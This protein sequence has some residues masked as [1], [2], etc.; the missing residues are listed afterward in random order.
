MSAFDKAWMV[1]KSLVPTSTDD[2]MGTRMIDSMFC[3]QC[4]QGLNPGSP[5]CE[6]CGASNPMMREGQ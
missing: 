2:P 6:K 4:K 1:L 3:Q 5:Q